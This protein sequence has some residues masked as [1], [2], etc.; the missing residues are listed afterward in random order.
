MDMWR[1]HSGETRDGDAPNED[2]EISCASSLRL[3]SAFFEAAASG[4]ILFRPL[5]KCQ[6]SLIRGT[7][8]LL[9]PDSVRN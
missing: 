7:A 8:L 9:T 3:F 6:V 5:G 4:G 1:A 2:G